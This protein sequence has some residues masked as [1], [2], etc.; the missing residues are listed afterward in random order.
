MAL[1]G[2][3]ATVADIQSTF[4]GVS[5]LELSMSGYLLAVK[6]CVFGDALSASS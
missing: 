3:A 5:G 6:R 2:R 1:L 4:K